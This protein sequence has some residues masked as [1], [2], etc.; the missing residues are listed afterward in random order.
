VVKARRHCPSPPAKTT[1]QIL[2][3]FALILSAVKDS[4]KV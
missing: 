2:R 4:D 1:I 3:R